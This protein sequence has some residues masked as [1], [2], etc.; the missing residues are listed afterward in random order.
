MNKPK[1][2]VVVG[3]SAGGIK[4]L[5]ELVSQFRPEMD[6]AVFIVMHLSRTGMQDFLYHRLKSHTTFTCQTAV[7]NS[8]IKRGHIYIAAPDYHL[9]IRKNKIILG[10]GPEE[11][12]WRPSIDVL[13]RSAAAAYSSRVIGIVLTG[14][15]DDG[16]TG[17]LAI[18][19][20]GGTCMVQEPTDAEYPDMPTS[21]IE[22]V[23]V[24]YCVPISRMGEVIYLTTLPVPVEMKAP[25]D[26]IIESEI[27][28]RVVIDYENVK[29]LGEKSIYACPDCGGGLWNINEKGKTDRYRCHI[30]HSYSEKDLAV[31]QVEV[32]ESTLWIALRMMEERRN[33]LKK[34]E[35]SVRKNGSTRIDVGYR[36]K[37]AELQL[38]VDRMKEILYAT[39]NSNSNEPTIL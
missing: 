1:Y 13:F 26:V 30:G 23:E 39:Q 28:E 34:M 16:T 15:L 6:M 8:P 3:T 12:R 14:S 37:G 21:I 10:R 32:L 27:A 24:D 35:N 2:I 38:H 22:N 19:R 31:K 11:N 7:E 5:T 33:L 4:A 25:A 20:S 18:K 36:D 9:L 29:Q 17:M